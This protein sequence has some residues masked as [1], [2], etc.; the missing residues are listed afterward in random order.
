MAGG[1]RRLAAA[2]YRGPAIGRDGPAA[3]RRRLR[4]GF[5]LNPHTRPRLNGPDRRPR[6]LG[7]L[8]G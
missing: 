1:V 7:R 3:A 8:G 5:R 2:L 4:Q 6:G